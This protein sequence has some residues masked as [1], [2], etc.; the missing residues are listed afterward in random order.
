M[1]TPVSSALHALLSTQPP[2]V[3]G[4]YSD[5][6]LEEAAI[7]ARDHIRDWYRHQLRQIIALLKESP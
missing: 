4:D 6:A 1:S 7:E 2:P 5:E 3:S